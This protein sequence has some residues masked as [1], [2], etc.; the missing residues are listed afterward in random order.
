MIDGK[1]VIQERSGTMGS[2]RV[3]LASFLCTFLH[4][5]FFYYL[6][7]EQFYLM[8]Q[9]Q[10]ALES[11]KV[12]AVP[13][14]AFLD[15]LGWSAPLYASF[16]YL[17]LLGIMF[18]GFLLLSIAFGSPLKRAVF[19][20]IGLVTITFLTFGDRVWGVFL[21]TMVLSFG[22]FYLLT[23]HSRIRFDQR[24]MSAF[25]AVVLLI[26]VSLFFGSKQKFFLKARDT[27]LFGSTVGNGIVSFYYQYSPLAAALV[28]PE[29][30]IYQGVLFD[31]DVK[32]GNVYY[33]GQGIFVTGNP[34]MSGS[35]DFQISRD[36]DKAF[37]TS[38]YGQR[39][40]IGPVAPL[41]IEKAI[42]SLFS[43]K[44]FVKLNTTSL[45]AFP[46]GLLILIGFGMRS[47]TG[48]KKTLVVPLGFIGLL[49]ISFI[50]IVSLTGNHPPDQ[51][52]LEGV[53]I[54]KEGLSLAY[55]LD[56]KR[57]VPQPYGPAV[58][59][60]AQ[61][62]SPVLRYWG[63]HLLGVRGNRED[64]NK[65]RQLLE[66]PVPNVRY[67]AA[68]SLYRL[69]DKES[70]NALVVRL[71]SD[72]SWYVRCKVYSLFLEAGMIPSPA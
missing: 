35:A 69:I 15:S 71:V 11:I 10:A 24:E 41:E 60:M 31:K 50:W 18:L 66:D 64:V 43:M 23:F 52:R 68:R 72:P 63:V 57:E 20:L 8:R 42:G 67:T 30:G 25:F 29:K 4:G 12:V 7:R 49:M 2:L 47:I 27:V 19:L 14:S 53:N 65:V 17:I 33:I 21:V 56:R 32:D 48:D 61:S 51:R 22:S 36:G 3:L 39:T 54:S 6:M 62:D 44:G 45:Y 59:K 70:L 1:K 58:K 37:L 16:F 5:S 40:G 13:G 46:A 34:V 28:T 9:K 26:C 55:F 38:R